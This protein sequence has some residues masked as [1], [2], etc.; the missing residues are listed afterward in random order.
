MRLDDITIRGDATPEELTAVLEA[1]RARQR[2]EQRLGRYEQWR[3]E[4]I[5][6][7]RSQSPDAR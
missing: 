7:L 4:R 3:R 1:L 2:T 6:V 5:R